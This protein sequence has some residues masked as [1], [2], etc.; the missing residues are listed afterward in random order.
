MWS[1]MWI[2]GTGMW[3]LR[4]GM[5]IMRSGMWTLRSGVWSG[6]WILGSGM[7]TMRSGMRTT[8]SRVEALRRRLG[9]VIIDFGGAP[10]EDWR[11]LPRLVAARRAESTVDVVV[12]RKGKKKTLPVKIGTL[13]E[14]PELAQATQPAAGLA[15]FGLAVQDL[16]TATILAL[17][18]GTV[19]WMLP[20]P[21]E[22]RG[23]APLY[24][25]GRNGEQT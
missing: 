6:M 7:W 11:E 13:E 15:E 10:V 3:T 25:A 16:T 20:F 2:L 23:A 5:W 24:W 9:D 4:S 1:G 18:Q 8:S 19:R 17:G 14:E 21:S 12:V 22:F